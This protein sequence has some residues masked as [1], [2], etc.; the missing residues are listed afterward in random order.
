MS[1]EVH[2]HPPLPPSTPRT[3]TQ[4]TPCPIPHPAPASPPASCGGSN[5]ACVRLWRED[6]G[7]RWEGRWMGRGG[8]GVRC[9]C[10]IGV[11]YRRIGRRGDGRSDGL[12]DCE[13]VAGY[14]RLHYQVRRGARCLLTRARR[15]EQE[16][17]RPDDTVD[18]CLAE[19]LHGGASKS[20]PTPSIDSSSPPRCGSIP[21]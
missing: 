20:D 18:G 6:G 1:E 9:R 15:V 5:R 3:G 11:C 21:I 2:L 14:C 12:G 19:R 10:V 17:R 4:D 16:G 7:C 13:V 8:G